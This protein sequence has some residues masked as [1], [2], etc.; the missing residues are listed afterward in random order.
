[1]I[2]FQRFNSKLENAIFG[3]MFVLFASLSGIYVYD[4]GLHPDEEW[5]YAEYGSRVLEGGIPHVDYQDSTSG[6]ISFLNA[7]LFKVFGVSILPPRIFL[8]VVFAL[9]IAVVCS[10][11]GSFIGA[12]GACV[13]CIVG[14]A[15][16]PAVYLA[17][18][19]QWYGVVLG[20]FS[21][22]GML[23]F[24]DK[25][26]VEWAAL[27]GFLAGLAMLM[28]P[29]IGLLHLLGF[30]VLQF[31]LDIEPAGGQLQDESRKQNAVNPSLI[32]QAVI[33]YLSLPVM[34]VV[35][36]RNGTT[37]AL[38]FC[39][40]V[41]FLFSTVLYAQWKRPPS[42]SSLKENA[43]NIAAALL[44]AGATV[45][46]VLLIYVSRG[47]VSILA[48]IRQVCLTLPAQSVDSL[49][50]GMESMEFLLLLPPN[51]F[52]ILTLARSK[53]QISRNVYAGICLITLLC[54]FLV[55]LPDLEHRNYRWAWVVHRWLLPELIILGAFVLFVPSSFQ[56]VDQKHRH[57]TLV[58]V[59]CASMFGF[60]QIP[61]FSGSSYLYVVAFQL[62]LTVSIAL[63]YITPK[64]SGEVH[65]AGPLKAMLGAWLL[66]LL[67]FSGVFLKDSETQYF[68]IAWKPVIYFD[69]LAFDRAKVYVDEKHIK[70]YEGIGRVVDVC[71]SVGQ[72]ILA[73]PNCHF[74]YFLT[75]RKNPFYSY[76]FPHQRSQDNN[77][78]GIDS[79]LQKSDLEL[80]VV[81]C[82]LQVSKKDHALIGSLLPVALRFGDFQTYSTELEWEFHSSVK[83]D[84]EVVEGSRFVKSGLWGQAEIND[85]ENWMN[86]AMESLPT[87]YDLGGE[88]AGQEDKQNNEEGTPESTEQRPKESVKVA[89]ALETTPD[90]LTPVNQ[91]V[92]IEDAAEKEGAEDS[93]KKVP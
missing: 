24:A 50:G 15:W 45:L 7:T 73:F 87:P 47:G 30:F 92:R 69:L 78:T 42:A 84:K 11:L 16:G 70:E 59:I 51:I 83:R 80:N 62:M 58:A 8:L 33:L 77:V 40:P 76:Q 53:Q 20:L 22:A 3:L 12:V 66:V 9:G 14:F 86:S 6:A 39:V 89:P 36:S 25:R 81:I 13:V 49:T 28:N 91:P 41:A 32:V 26:R 90:E 37:A 88:N 68:G 79:A 63:P 64:E 85:W 29:A 48:Q 21:L 18:S 38:Y 19:P 31:A 10:L 75:G 71:T 27:I 72:P 43:V 65:T 23:K 5:R 56:V 44:L 55:F 17:P 93:E 2:I 82:G 61:D 35:S 4:Q 60:L 52:F 74:A 34:W 54:M 1:M 67:C 57:L 46:P